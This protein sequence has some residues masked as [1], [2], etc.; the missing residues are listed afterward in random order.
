MVNGQPSTNTPK[1]TQK[2]TFAGLT[3]VPDIAWTDHPGTSASCAARVRCCH[4]NHTV[5][6][7]SPIM[8]MAQFG[9]R[10]PLSHQAQ[11]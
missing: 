5:E 9:Y 8:S 4:G 10:E 1:K 2:G 6:C 3:K 7:H 11:P